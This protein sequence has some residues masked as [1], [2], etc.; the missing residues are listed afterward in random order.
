[1]KHKYLRG[2]T[3][4]L[5]GFIALT[6]IAGGI[7]ILAGLEDFPAEWLEGSI[8]KSYTIPA[9]ILSVVVGGSSLA[10]TILFIKKHRLANKGLIAAGAIMM[11]QIIGEIIILNQEPPVPSGIEIFYFVLGLIVLIL[12]VFFSRKIPA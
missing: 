3:I 4:F 10:A 11:G 2:L 6:A 5:A 1:M 7:A 9:I 8:F 12:G